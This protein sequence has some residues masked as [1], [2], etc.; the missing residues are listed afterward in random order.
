M[1]IPL[2]DEVPVPDLDAVAVRRWMARATR[3]SPW[4]HEEVARRMVDRL[5]WFRQ[6][7]ASWLHWEPVNGGLEAHRLLKERLPQARGAFWSSCTAAPQL[8]QAGAL[9][10]LGWLASRWRSVSRTQQSE[11][12]APQQTDLLWANM[13]LHL[14]AQPQALMRHWQQLVKP[15]GFLMF[16]CLGPDSLRELRAVYAAM[17]WHAPAHAFTDMHDWGDMLV[18]AGFAEPVMDMERMVLTWSTPE[19][20]LDE[21]RLSGRNFHAARPQG[22]RGRQWRMRLLQAL[23]ERLP[24]TDEGRLQVSFEIIYGHAFQGEPRRKDPARVPLEEM[25]AML[26]RR[27]D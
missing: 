2:S 17:G 18:R 7:P 22:L 19:A 8:L 26:R 1:S 21:L 14:A 25:R 16:S 13:C 5:Q 11:D 9:P 10:G 12:T 27:P 4:L 23:E 15:Q 6:A 20:L 3:Q 24:R